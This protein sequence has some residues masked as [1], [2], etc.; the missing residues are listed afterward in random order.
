MSK[1]EVETSIRNIREIGE[2]A[3]HDP[4]LRKRLLASI[5]ERVLTKQPELTPLERYE[6]LMKLRDEAS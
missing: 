4:E 1:E 5:D 2:Q 3:R 6:R